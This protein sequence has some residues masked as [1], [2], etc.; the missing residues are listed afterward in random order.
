[1]F[2][3]DAL[4]WF[5][6]AL[7]FAAVEVEIEGRYGWAEKLPTWYR[8]AGFWAR[9]YALVMR[10]KPL[11]GYHLFMFFLPLLAL[12]GAFFLGAPFTLRNELMI[13]ANYACWV[14]LWDYLWFVLNPAYGSA[15]FRKDKVW[16]Y[17]RSRWLLGRLPLE[18]ALSV[19]LSLKLALAAAFFAGDWTVFTG[20][21]LR[22]ACLAFLLAPAVVFI[23]PPYRRWHSKMRRRDDRDRAGIFH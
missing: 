23:G 18:Y 22:L 7:V 20:H 4:F 1:M 5:T 8:T 21:L 12:H 14:S 11:T 3:A 16:W 13:L 2:V 9:L 10:G 17:A 15:G 6:L 19:A